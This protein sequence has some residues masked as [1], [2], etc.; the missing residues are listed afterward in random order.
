MVSIIIVNFNGGGHTRNCLVSLAAHPP[1]VP[2]E[3]ILVDNGSTDGSREMAGADF[4]TVKILPL[5]RNPGFGAANNAGAR[6]AEGEH[7]F[8]LNNDT[9][10]AEDIVSPLSLLLDAHPDWGVIGPRVRNPDGS[11]Q[12]S[13]GR[14]PT[15]GGERRTRREMRLLRK[16][17]PATLADFEIRYARTTPV[18][19]ISGAALFARRE[20]FDAVGG[21][22]EGYFL[23]FED[24]DLC[25][26]IARAG[27]AV[28]HEPAR[29][30]VH[31][32]GMSYEPN[33][34]SVALE[35]RRS[36]LRYYAAH[37]PPH[38]RMLL[39]IY[40]FS[41][42]LLRLLRRRDPAHC[43]GV[44]GLLFRRRRG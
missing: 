15:P 36:Q 24:A 3:I 4:P 40:L 30:L 19:W 12:L 28:I 43:L 7:L 41:L 21:F 29:S 16:R 1:A 13:F 26:R 27:F 14:F 8:F 34:A 32:G 11:F 25:R 35:Y 42:Y 17:D 5:G 18:D 9:L 10:V 33:D 23:Y 38:Q 6:E 44:L 2:H 31:L 22:D 37:N 39:R 20:A